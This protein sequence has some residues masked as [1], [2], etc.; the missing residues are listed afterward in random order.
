MLSALHVAGK[1]G[2]QGPINAIAPGVLLHVQDSVSGVFFLVDTGAAFSVLPYIS[3]SPPTGPA[4][5]GPN[6]VNIPCWGEA[7]VTLC[8]DNRRFQW[9]FVK[10][11]VDFAI[12]GVDFLSKF[13]LSVDVAAGCLRSPLFGPVRC[14]RGPPALAAVHPSSL[15]SPMELDQAPSLQSSNGESVKV[16]TGSRVAAGGEK[17]VV[18]KP[19]E[20]ID[21]PSNCRTLHE[22][23]D[24]FSTVLN[25]EG[26]L[27]PT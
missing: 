16:P 6:G 2:S 19:E 11:A 9:T 5:R 22:L 26:R 20:T 10:A 18:A 24:K 13:N 4:L 15:H 27:P 12:I 1:L 14:T 23:L 21:S 25:A 3:A 8:L 17:A 7:K